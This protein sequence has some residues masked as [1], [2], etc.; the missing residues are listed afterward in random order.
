MDSNPKRKGYELCGVCHHLGSPQGDE[1][2]VAPGMVCVAARAMRPIGI[3][4]GDCAC[5]VVAVVVGL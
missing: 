1:W 2:L 4:L 3:T 5:L